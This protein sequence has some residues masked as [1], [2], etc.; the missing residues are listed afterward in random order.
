MSTSPR[1]P[2]ARRSPR[3]ALHAVL[4]AL[5]VAPFPHLSAITLGA[6]S[7]ACAALAVRLSAAHTPSACLCAAALACLCGAFFAEA[8]ARSRYFEYARLLTLLRRHGWQ[9]RLVRPLCASR[10]QRDATKAAAIDAGYG[11]E[12]VGY[13]KRRGYR[14]HHL[15]PDAV[16]QRPGNLFTVRFLRSSF[17]AKRGRTSLP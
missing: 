2:A 8:D 14:W 5:R 15:I 9:E 16:L 10:C 1:T 6:A 13:F 4:I 17:F 12:I 3:S 11:R 7:L